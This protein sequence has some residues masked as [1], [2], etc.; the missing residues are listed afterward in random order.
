[1]IGPVAA[2]L[3]V[4]Y[5]GAVAMSAAAWL[6]AWRGAARFATLRELTGIADRAVL[7]RLFGRP[8]PDG[9]FKVSIAAILRHRRLPGTIL[10]DLPVHLLFLV[11]TTSAAT[12][13]DAATSAAILSGGLI[14][15]VVV[16]G[17]ALL[18][19]IG[20]RQVLFD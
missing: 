20:R 12:A 14:H 8:A 19:L 15:F 5:A 7:I 11:A 16:A 18:V 6:S 13:P 17:A 9:S 4:F 1:M 3:L 10:S 2:F